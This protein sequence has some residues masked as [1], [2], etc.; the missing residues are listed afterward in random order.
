MLPSN[1]C[2]CAR[3]V[4]R[5]L[6]DTNSKYHSFNPLKG[7]HSSPRERDTGCAGL[8]FLFAHNSKEVLNGKDSFSS[9]I[10][11]GDTRSPKK[12]TIPPANCTAAV[13]RKAYWK[14]EE[15][16]I[17]YTSGILVRPRSLEA[18]VGKVRTGSR[19]RGIGKEMNTECS[20]H[21]RHGAVSLVFSMHCALEA[22][23]GQLRSQPH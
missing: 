19:G 7:P 16:G 18:H 13:T 3:S 17:A 11:S 10:S 20:G 8:R 12:M 21:A 23:R 5:C 9:P 14:R 1:M 6:W 15:R 2:S 4:N 22:Q